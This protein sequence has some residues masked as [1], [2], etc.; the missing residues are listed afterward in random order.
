MNRLALCVLGIIP[1]ATAFIGVLVWWRR[2]R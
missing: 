2:R 1:T